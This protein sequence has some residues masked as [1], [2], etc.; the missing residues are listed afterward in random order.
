MESWK[1][2]I[3]N[4][5][6]EGCQYTNAATEGVNS[7]I[8]HLNDLGRGYKFETLRIKALYHQSSNR[9][10]KREN[11]KSQLFDFKV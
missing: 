8:G 2:Y 3:F 5:F 7:M 10:P 9:I 6:E 4:Y 11:K 1:E